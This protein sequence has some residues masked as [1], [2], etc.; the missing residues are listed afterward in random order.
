MLYH[1]SIYIF[2]IISLIIL[3]EIAAYFW[4]YLGTHRDIIPSIFQVQKTHGIH[5]NTIDDQAHGDFFYVLSFL[6]LF[7]ISLIYLYY[8][9]FLS[10]FQISIIYIPVFL[11]FLWNWYIHSAYHI[12]NHWL[13]SYSW[14]QEDK[15]LHFQHHENPETNFGIASHFSDVMFDTFDYGLLQNIS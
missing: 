3:T 7:L 8:Q 9:N 4:H 13:N 2:I 6:T 5:H 1:Y 12:E 10:L 11:T 15:R 14:F